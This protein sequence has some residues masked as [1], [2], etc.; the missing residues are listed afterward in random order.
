MDDVQAEIVLSSGL[1][2]GWR[3]L[4]IAA[5]TRA[6]RIITDENNMSF[7]IEQLVAGLGKWDWKVVSFHTG[8]EPWESYTPAVQDFNTKHAR[9]KEKLKLAMHEARMA[10]IKAENPLN[11]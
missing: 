10:Q 9:L 8:D 6:L 2:S 1:A 11:G 7:R 4:A 3:V 5:P